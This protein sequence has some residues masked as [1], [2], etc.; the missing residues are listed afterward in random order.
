MLSEWHESLWPH[1]TFVAPEWHE[2][3]DTCAYSWNS[4]TWERGFHTYFIR[5][6]TVRGHIQLDD[7]LHAASPLSIQALFLYGTSCTHSQT[8]NR[9]MINT[10][11]RRTPCHAAA[12]VLFH[13]QQPWCTQSQHHN[14][15]LTDKILLIISLQLHLSSQGTPRIVHKFPDR[16]SQNDISMLLQLPMHVNLFV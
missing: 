2:D 14:Q 11:C 3:V 12:P 9:R 1:C 15:R 10:P 13:G 5:K 7:D 4:V 8:E 16:E 6:N